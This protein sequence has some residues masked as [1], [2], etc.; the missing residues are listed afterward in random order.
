MKACVHVDDVLYNGTSDRILDEF[1]RLAN[2]YFGECTGGGVADF[3]LG[4]KIE[5]DLEELTVK[6]SQ[7]AHVVSHP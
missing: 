6:L 2:N 7:R 1:F 4:I 5:W 3:V